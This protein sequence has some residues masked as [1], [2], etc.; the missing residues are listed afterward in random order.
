LSWF[1]GLAIMVLLTLIGWILINS[2]KEAEFRGKILTKIE[3]IES[4]VNDMEAS[5]KED[6]KSINEYIYN[7]NLSIQEIN[8]HLIKMGGYDP[9]IRSI[10]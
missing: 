3:N 6:I 2:V 5:H 10:K 8:N 4:T 1:I 9:T 7:Y